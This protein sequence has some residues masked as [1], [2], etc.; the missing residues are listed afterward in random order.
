MLKKTFT[1]LGFIIIFALAVSL[2]FYMQNKATMSETQTAVADSISETAEADAIH[3]YKAENL[4]AECQSDS[5]IFCAIE[6][7]VKCTI[8][9]ELNNCDKKFVPPFVVGKAIDTERPTEIS[10]R[11]TKIKPLPES[12]NI[13]VYTQSD[14]NALWFGLCKGTVVYSLTTK[15]NEWAVTNIFALEE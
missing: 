8:N 13:S 12:D 11:I 14:C 15:N 9:P 1:I 10:F 4:P 5:D 3:T 6:R 2:I 7:T